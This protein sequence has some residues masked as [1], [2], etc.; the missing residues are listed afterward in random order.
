MSAPQRFSGTRLRAI[1]ED[2]EC[3]REAL[4]TASGRS[5]E[6]ISSY[7]LGR[8][9]PSVEALVSMA[10]ALHAEVGDLFESVAQEAA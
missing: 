4:A 3:T 2:R 7:E 5:Y 9:V 8:S 1:R 6:S 10:A